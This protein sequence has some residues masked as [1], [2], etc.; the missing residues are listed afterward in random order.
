MLKK[1][2]VTLLTT[3]LISAGLAG[4]SSFTTTAQGADPYPGTVPTLCDTG[5]PHTLRSGRSP[6]SSLYVKPAGSGRPKGSVAVQYI[7]QPTGKVRG[8]KSVTYSG[9]RVNFRGPKLNKPGRWLIRLTFDTPSKSVYQGC[10]DSYTLTV[11]RG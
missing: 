7:Y 6:R 10:K 5:G 1:T 2:L 4:V 9:K 8:A 11:K 3:A